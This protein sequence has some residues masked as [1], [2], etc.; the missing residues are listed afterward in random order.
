MREIAILFYLNMRFEC[1]VCKSR[2]WT[3]CSF[4]SLLLSS[5]LFL[6][7]SFF[8]FFCL[9]GFSSS[10]FFSFFHILSFLSCFLFFPFLFSTF[11]HFFFSF[12]LF[13]IFL[14][15]LHLVLTCS[16]YSP[17]FLLWPSLW[18]QCRSQVSPRSCSC[19]PGGAPGRRRSP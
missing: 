6:F 1:E 11:Y 14:F 19:R 4:F 13:F 15:L 16:V 12:F 2:Q 8:S 5:F 18:L 9:F 17:A 3:F 7:F 10:L